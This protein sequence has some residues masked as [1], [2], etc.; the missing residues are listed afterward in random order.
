M[1]VNGDAP[2]DAPNWSQR[3]HIHNALDV[4][5]NSAAAAW[6]VHTLNK[7]SMTYSDTF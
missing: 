7:S 2:L 3:H 1:Q 4:A 6:C 5:A